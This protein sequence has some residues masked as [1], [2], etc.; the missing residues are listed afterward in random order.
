MP[1]PALWRG[2][3]KPPVRGPLGR[4]PV[5]AL[6]V[7]GLTGRA[8]LGPIGRPPADGA[9]RRCPGGGGIGRPVELIG[10][11]GGGAIGRPLGDRG[12]RVAAGRSSPSPGRA[13]GR[14]VVGPSAGT[15]R[16]GAGLGGAVRVRTTR[17]ASALASLGRA[18]STST[19]GAAGT[20][21][22]S[23]TSE[24]DRTAFFGAGSSGAT[25]RRSPSAS[26]LRRTRSA[27]ASSI[28]DEALF[29]PMPRDPARSKSSLLVRP[30]SRASSWTRIFFAANS[31]PHC[32]DCPGAKSRS[33]QSLILPSCDR[34]DIAR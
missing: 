23:G 25:A 14:I 4:V 17:G 28:E 22:G 26:A 11:R 6:I 15:V 33:F 31:F 34:G 8:P 3:P 18:L 2:P 7:R 27:C 20:M 30:S 21:T 10:G 24:P 5:V 16:T 32:G 29:T 19:T 9:V 1:N 12:G 13:V